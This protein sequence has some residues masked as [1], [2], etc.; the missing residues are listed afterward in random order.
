VYLGAGG[1]SEVVNSAGSDGAMNLANSFPAL[2]LFLGG[3]V[4]SALTVPS[5]EAQGFAPQEAVRRMSVATGLDVCL[6]AAEPIVRQPV[7]IEFDD[8]GRL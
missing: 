4:F 6:V 3:L 8:R 5:A 2:G 7:A 1:I